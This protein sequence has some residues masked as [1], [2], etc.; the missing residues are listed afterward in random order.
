MIEREKK[1][2]ESIIEGEKNGK[3]LKRRETCEKLW[4]LKMFI[5]RFV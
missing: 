4:Q 1:K 2:K 3:E 5:A